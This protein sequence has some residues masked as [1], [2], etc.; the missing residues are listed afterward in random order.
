MQSVLRGVLQAIY[1]TII[2]PLLLLDEVSE[3]SISDG[4]LILYADDI[5]ILHHLQQW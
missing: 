4:S 2:G 5:V 1:L 3:V